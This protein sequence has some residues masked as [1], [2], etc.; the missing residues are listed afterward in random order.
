MKSLVMALAFLVFGQTSFAGD[1][2]TPAVK[3]SFNNSFK[4]AT[5]VAWTVNDNF[6]KASFV[7]NSQYITAFYSADGKMIAVSRNI[8]STQLPIA[9]QANLKMACRNYWISDLI[10][11][12]NEEGTVYYVTL[13]NADTKLILKSTPNSD[14]TTFGKQ[15]KS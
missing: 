6:Y 9:L 1:D 11:L 4:N 15:R 3:E 5:E 2:V 7:F 12:A 13:E 14:W 10:E 8:S